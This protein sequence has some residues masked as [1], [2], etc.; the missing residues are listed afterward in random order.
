MKRRKAEVLSFKVDDSLVEAMRGI[1]NRSEF[2]R[3]AILAALDSAC[4]LCKGTGI[5]TPNQRKHWSSFA[6]DHT[7]KECSECN[8]LHLVCSNE[9]KRMAHGRRR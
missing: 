2:I 6:V 3:S 8:E 5:L 9:P 4:P 1:P 7:I